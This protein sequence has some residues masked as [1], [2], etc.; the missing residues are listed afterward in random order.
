MFGWSKKAKEEEALRIRE[1]RE[2]EEKLKIEEELRKAEEKRRKNMVNLSCKGSFKFYIEEAEEQTRE[3][4]YNYRQAMYYH[5]IVTHHLYIDYDVEIL[6]NND[7]YF[8]RDKFIVTDLPSEESGY[9][10]ISESIKDDERMESIY[11]SLKYQLVG[12]L[13]KY[14]K[15][16][17]VEE[18][19]KA[20]K[21][22]NSFEFDFSFETE[23][24]K[25]MK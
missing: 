1:E 14:L 4:G 24:T 8:F 22:N 5:L 15:E 18:M 17:N 21:E 11:D 6:Y 20:L 13:E 25:H 2:R 23:K 12:K 7:V 9:E 16:R 19:R 10:Y 3:V